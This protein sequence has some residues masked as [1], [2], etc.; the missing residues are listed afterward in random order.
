[1]NATEKSKAAIQALVDGA[2]IPDAEKSRHLWLAAAC[3]VECAKAAEHAAFLAMRETEG[4]QVQSGFEFQQAAK[5]HLGEV[6]TQL[7]FLGSLCRGD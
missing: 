3:L 4:G 1:M 7:I 2:P 6:K 5:V